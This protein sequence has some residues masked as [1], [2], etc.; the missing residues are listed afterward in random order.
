MAKKKQTSE[1]LLAANVKAP[2]LATAEYAAFAEGRVAAG[3][4]AYMMRDSAW[5]ALH[6]VATD[7]QLRSL[8]ENRSLR[9]NREPEFEQFVRRRLAAGDKAQVIIDSITIAAHD[10]L[11]KAQRDGK[12]LT[13]KQRAAAGGK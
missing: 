11:D 12:T 2:E 8:F 6:H 5:A 13:K 3:D 9:V 7:E 10:A 4:T 1:E